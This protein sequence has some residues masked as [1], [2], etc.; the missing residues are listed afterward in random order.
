LRYLWRGSRGRHRLVVLA[1]D[2][3]GNRSSYESHVRLSG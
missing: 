1:V 3:V 2:G